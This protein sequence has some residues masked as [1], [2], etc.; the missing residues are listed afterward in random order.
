MTEYSPTW[1]TE[2]GY[3]LATLPVSEKPKGPVQ[4]KVVFGK[5]VAS[6]TN[7]TRSQGLSSLAVI[8]SF[9]SQISSAKAAEKT[10]PAAPMLLLIQCTSMDVTPAATSTSSSTAPLVFEDPVR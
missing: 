6:S 10:T 2:M 7:S 3:L 4:V 8:S 1:A 5:S 9:C